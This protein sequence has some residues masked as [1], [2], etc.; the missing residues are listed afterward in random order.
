MLT[1]LDLLAKHNALQEDKDP[2]K[3]LICLKQRIIAPNFL[4]SKRQLCKKVD[5]KVNPE[6][7]DHSA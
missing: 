5:L 4:Q 2:N 1:N 7:K 6:A 3:S